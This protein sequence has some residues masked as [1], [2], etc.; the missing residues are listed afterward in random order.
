MLT[1][2]SHKAIDINYRVHKMQ[3]GKETLNE[4]SMA[5]DQ[6]LALPEELLFST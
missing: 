1:P 4:G 2:H 6:S 5:L 3:D